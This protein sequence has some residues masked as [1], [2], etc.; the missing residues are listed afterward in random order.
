M[1]DWRDVLWMQP[2]A[3]VGVGDGWLAAHDVATARGKVVLEEQRRLGV[4]LGSQV[5]KPEVNCNGDPHI[6]Q[7]PQGGRVFHPPK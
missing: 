1:I 4:L 5:L 7:Q 6:P 2:C 3:L